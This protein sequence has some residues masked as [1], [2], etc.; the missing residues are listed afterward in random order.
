MVTFTKISTILK[1]DL[2]YE[3][4]NSQVSLYYYQMHYNVFNDT[5]TIKTI[6]VIKYYI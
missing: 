3:I 4:T 2:K 1:D 5:K 6:E